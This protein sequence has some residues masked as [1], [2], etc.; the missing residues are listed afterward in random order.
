MGQKANMIK[1]KKA[2]MSK[3]YFK[4]KQ[5]NKC[6]SIALAFIKKDGMVR[7]NINT[8]VLT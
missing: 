7:A 8:W 5:F 4:L 6:Q 1:N 2:G 3:S